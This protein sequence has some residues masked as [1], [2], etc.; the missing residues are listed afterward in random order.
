MPG[1]GP[2]QGQ[3]GSVVP[4]SVVVVAG[5]VDVV[6][7][8]TLR[9]VV[10]VDEVVDVV[11]VVEVAG[12]RVVVDEVGG[13]VVVEEVEVLLVVEVVA[14]TDVVVVG[15]CVVVEV[16]GGDVV[17]LVVVETGTVA[18]HP[19]AAT[20]SSIRALTTSPKTRS[21]LP[22]PPESWWQ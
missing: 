14:A 16:V 15:G 5:D 3:G 13:R 8:V 22:R 4:G 2:A 20:L 1:D 9:V 12:G 6:D 11:V 17:L 10:D 19:A 21:M 7:V 18:R